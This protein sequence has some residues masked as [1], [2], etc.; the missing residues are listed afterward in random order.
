MLVR[1]VGAQSHENRDQP[2]RIDR[3]EHRDEREQEFLNR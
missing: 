1:R 2:D 3:D